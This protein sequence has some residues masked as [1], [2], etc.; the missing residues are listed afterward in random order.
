MKN[1]TRQIISLVLLL[2]FSVAS[3]SCLT[4]SLTQPLYG[5]NFNDV[6]FYSENDSSLHEVHSLEERI[7]LAAGVQ[8]IYY[9]LINDNKPD[10]LVVGNPGRIFKNYSGLIRHKSFFTTRYTSQA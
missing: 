5:S 1:I 10:E 6:L 3:L 4:G 2:T 8:D 9:P 7:K